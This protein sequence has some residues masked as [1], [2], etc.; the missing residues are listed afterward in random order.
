MVTIFQ[1]LVE[2][3]SGKT[4]LSS[5]IHSIDGGLF[6]PSVTFCNKN[7][8]KNTQPNL[9]LEDYLANS[10]NLED[11]FVNAS[12]GFHGQSTPL[13]YSV[14]T[15]FG[16]Y[17]GRCYTFDFHDK[18]P[19]QALNSLVIKTG[20]NLEFFIHQPGDEVWLLM[21][22][23]PSRPKYVNVGQEVGMLDVPIKKSVF[24]KKKNCDAKELPKRNGK[25]LKKLFPFFNIILI[26]IDCLIEEF[27][28]FY[29]NLGL[30]CTLPFIQNMKGTN[31]I[32]ES[33][34]NKN[35]LTRV[36]YSPTN[37]LTNAASNNVEKCLSKI[38]Y[39]FSAHQTLH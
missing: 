15:T 38:H 30:N 6:L 8:Y 21:G 26:F 33:V 3:I 39:A 7:G 11:F 23:C 13:D 9:K 19:A 34:C 27:L 14:K 31:D 22:Y 35:D 4:T 2:F 24:L 36:L 32:N 29:D 17:R 16:L 1:T 18:F 25:L 12:S 20:Q 10:I 5:Q 37:P 28:K